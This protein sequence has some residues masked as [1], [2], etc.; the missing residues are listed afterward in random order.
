M[1]SLKKKYPFS[2]LATVID[3][4]SAKKKLVLWLSAFC[5]LM[6]VLELSQDMISSAVNGNPFS[7]SD[8][9]SYKLFWPLFIPFSLVL[10]KWWNKRSVT[11]LNSVVTGIL[12]VLTAFAHLILFSLL[13]FSISSV[14]YKESWSL[15]YLLTEK[16]STRLYIALACYIILWATYYY[17]VKTQGELS[18]A[19][20]RSPQKTGH[21]VVKNGKRSVRVDIN[22][23]KWIKADGQYLSVITTKN[24]YVVLDS[25]KNIIRSLPDHFKRIH[26]ST[27]ANTDIIEELQSRGN[28]DYDLLTRDGEILR[29]SRTYAKPVK[30]ILL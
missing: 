11:P 19:D 17:R 14:L 18:H 3:T 27:I 22:Q 7:I 10:I 28:G 21:L 5:F 9:L 16:L 26:R 13:L 20:N 1:L 23:I 8:S 29:L 2:S 6:M 30:K 25:L 4:D 12:V 15:Y 24:T